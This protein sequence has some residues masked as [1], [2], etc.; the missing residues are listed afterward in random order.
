M[1]KL[2]DESIEVLAKVI[3]WAY[4]NEVEVSFFKRRTY[5]DISFPVI[6]FSRGNKHL[7]ESW[8]PLVDF[9]G[10]AEHLWAAV[11]MKLCVTPL[12]L[13]NPQEPG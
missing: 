5:G 12:V 6:R 11:A 1:S 3:A 8:H 13:K 2:C 9:T 4:E 10:L 7:E